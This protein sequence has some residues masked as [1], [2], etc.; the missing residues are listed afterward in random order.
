MNRENIQKLINVLKSE[1]NPVAFG[2]NGWFN[3]NLEGV[4]I[5][6]ISNTV[7]DHACGTVA[8]IAGQAMI[9][10]LEEDFPVRSNI[11]TTAAA[12]LGLNTNDSHNLFYGYWSNRSRYDL[13]KITKE[14]AIKE[15]K[16]LISEDPAPLVYL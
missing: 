3:H 15:L 12:W 6:E 5:S 10:L 14:E 4:E 2:M 13:T 7:R 16:R 11:H 9:L 1:D 8:C